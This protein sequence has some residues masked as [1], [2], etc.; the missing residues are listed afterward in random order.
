MGIPRKSLALAPP[1]GTRQGQVRVGTRC[2]IPRFGHRTHLNQFPGLNSESRNKAVFE[3][4]FQWARRWCHAGSE[5]EAS[6]P[7]E[8]SSYWKLETRIRKME[9]RRR[10]RGSGV[11]GGL[12]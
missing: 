2:H 9:R 4:H 8:T 1:S 11:E 3:Q 5:G 10:M 12:D 7:R 6:S